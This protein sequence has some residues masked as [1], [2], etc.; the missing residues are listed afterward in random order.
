LHGP[1]AVDGEKVPKIIADTP[2][3]R[4]SEFISLRLMADAPDSTSADSSARNA[5]S[6]I[7]VASARPEN[8]QSS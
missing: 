5:I 6:D 4:K 3:A 1:V 7:D 8:A 2:T